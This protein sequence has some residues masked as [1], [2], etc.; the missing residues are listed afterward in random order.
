MSYYMLLFY[1]NAMPAQ[2]LVLTFLV[3]IIWDNQ[4]TE[5]FD[6]E[7]P[8]LDYGP[9]KLFVESQGCLIRNIT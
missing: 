3:N 9:L 7:S 1:T 2:I 5:F 4:I 6:L 8:E